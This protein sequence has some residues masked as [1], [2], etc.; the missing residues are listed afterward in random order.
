MA[1]QHAANLVADLIGPNRLA[2]EAIE[3]SIFRAQPSLVH[4]ISGDRCD[5]RVRRLILISLNVRQL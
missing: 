4:D 3:A 1:V 2:D 5:M